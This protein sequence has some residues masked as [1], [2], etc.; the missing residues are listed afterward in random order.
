MEREISNQSLQM[1]QEL[2]VESCEMISGGETL[3]YWVT[4]GVIGF[5]VNLNGNQSSGQRL[6]NSALA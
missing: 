2:P 3:W 5:F 1:M 4:Y 6:Y